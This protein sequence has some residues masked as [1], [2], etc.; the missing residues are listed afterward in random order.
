MKVKL[1]HDLVKGKRKNCTWNYGCHIALG[2]ISDG[3]DGGGGNDGE[4]GSSLISPV[5][6][7][8][9]TV[10]GTERG[11]AKHVSSEICPCLLSSVHSLISLLNSLLKKKC[12]PFNIF[13]STVLK[14][15]WF[16]KMQFVSVYLSGFSHLCNQ[17]P[18]QETQHSQTPT[19]PALISPSCP[20][21]F[22]PLS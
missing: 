4:H 7:S 14:L 15:T 21:L 17:H 11:P 18:D 12:F 2:S 22:T 13:I 10:L 8:S 16:R 20:F 9:S 6:P 3:G 1:V 5:G 19:S